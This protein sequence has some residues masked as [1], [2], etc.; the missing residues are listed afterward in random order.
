MNRPRQIARAIALI[1]VL[2]TSRAA[3]AQGN[4]DKSEVTTFALVNTSFGESFTMTQSAFMFNYA[5]FFTENDQIGA[6]P[7]IFISRFA[8]HTESTVGFNSFYRRMLRPRGGGEVRPYVGGEFLMF[9]VKP[10]AGMSVTDSMFLSGIAGI[11]YYFTDHV[12]LDTKA[13]FGF[14]PGGAGQALQLT[15]GI[16]YLF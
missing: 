4:Y 1:L 12:G 8:G 5:R 13:S 15:V 2:L 6:G 10:T 7:T 11:K 9:D 14:S 16:S 3:F